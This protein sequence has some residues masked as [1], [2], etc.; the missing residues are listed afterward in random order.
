MFDQEVPVPTRI[1][2][3]G[4]FSTRQHLHPTLKY[5]QEKVIAVKEENTH[6]KNDKK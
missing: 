3:P 1:R 5:E 6:Y 2:I 4:E